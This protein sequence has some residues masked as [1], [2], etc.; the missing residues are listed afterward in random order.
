LGEGPSPANWTP[1]Y[2]KK[3]DLLLRYKI[4][5]ERAFQRTFRLLEQFCKL[6]PTV[7]SRFAESTVNKPAEPVILGEDPTSPT[8]T[9]IL[10]EVRN[11]VEN[12]TP[13][14]YYPSNKTVARPVASLKSG[15]TTH[16]VDN[17]PTSYIMVEKKTVCQTRKPISFRARSISS[18]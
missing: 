12:T 3:H 6:H 15:A 10:H 14:P 17:Q 4:T 16:Y 18:S 11:G 9:T 13:R 8:G 5:A 1:D 2:I 7:A